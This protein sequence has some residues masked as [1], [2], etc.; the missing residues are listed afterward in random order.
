MTFKIKSSVVG[1]I[2]RCWRATY[3]N[4]FHL[5]PQISNIATFSIV[6]HKGVSDF[7]INCPRI[8]LVTILTGEHESN[9]IWYWFAIPESVAE[10]LV[11]TMQVELAISLIAVKLDSLAIEDELAMVDAISY[12]ANNA[13]MIITFVF[14][15][16]VKSHYYISG[17]ISFGSWMRDF[18]DTCTIIGELN[19]YSFSTTY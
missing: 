4:A 11:S 3:K 13:S 12:T 19:D 7:D 2:D 10:A 16:F 18:S 5:K 9:S 8:A 15:S 14:M 1:Q 17:I 6:F